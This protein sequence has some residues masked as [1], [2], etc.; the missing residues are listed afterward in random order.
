MMHIDTSRFG[1]IEAS[2][3][4]LIRFPGGVIGF[5]KETRFVL[6]PHGS[7]AFIAWLQSTTTPDLAF[8][9]VSAHG[10]PGYPDVPLDV[11]ADRAG[12]GGK[13]DDIA[14]L[15]VLSA[16]HSQPA[17]VNL[18]AP[19]LINAATRIG[20]QV[21]LEGSRFSTQELFGF[22]ADPQQATSL[23]RAASHSP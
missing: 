17:T 21:F 22:P 7:S 13:H 8:P 15:A 10:F 16:P 11:A 2:D 5:R 18:L 23:P 1:T 6:I 9:V 19:L 12:I 20:A 4:D 3:N 14:L